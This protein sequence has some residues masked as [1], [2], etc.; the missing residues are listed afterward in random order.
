MNAKLG[1]VKTQV[2]KEIS[3]YNAQ[4][5]MILR[6]SLTEYE[7]DNVKDLFDDIFGYFKPIGK[8]EELLVELI[9][10]C[11]VKLTRLQKS[12]S[13]YIKSV[14][15]PHIEGDVISDW[16]TVVKSEGYIPKIGLESMD[17]LGSTYSRYETA[18]ENRLYRS[19]HELE[20][21]RRVRDGESVS[22][23][24]VADVTS[25]GSFGNT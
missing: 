17:V 15:H 5:H 2:G 22:S 11:L 20:R 9:I 12:E 3:R 24:I 6:E 10:V 8:L 23:P 14:L 1:G 7:D 21:L 4:K 16:G 25:L 18:I 19:I 13:E